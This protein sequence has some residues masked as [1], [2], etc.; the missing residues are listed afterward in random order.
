L[1]VKVLHGDT[2]SNWIH[3]G[4]TGAPNPYIWNEHAIRAAYERRRILAVLVPFWLG[5]RC[6]LAN[7][8]EVSWDEEELAWELATEYAEGSPVP[9]LH[10]LRTESD[11]F[12]RLRDEVMR[13]LVGRLRQSGFDGAVWQA[14]LGNPVAL[15]NFLLA[16]DGGGFH[17]I[18][19]ESGVPAIFPLNPL[20]LFGYYLPMCLKHRRALFDDVDVSR[21][22]RYLDEQSGV[23]AATLGS[24]TLA[25]LRERTEKLQVHQD[26]WKHQ[27][28]HERG[29]DYQLAK[30]RLSDERATYYRNRPLRWHLREIRRATRKLARWVAVE[31]PLRVGGALGKVRPAALFRRMWRFSSS[32]AYR[33]GVAR[34]YVH[35][36]LDHWE[37]RNRME[38]AHADQLREELRDASESTSYITDLGAH[39]GMKGAFITLELTVLAGL[40][41]AGVISVPFVAV[42]LALDGVISRS[43]YT[44]YRSG[45]AVARRAPL[46]WIAFLVGLAP[47]FGNSAYAV[48]MLYAANERHHHIARFILC[49]AFT[50]L[51]A[52]MPV[53]GGRDTMTEHVFN[54][55][56]NRLAKRRIA[57]P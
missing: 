53:W 44:L 10:P 54:R 35:A 25:E 30:R 36:R 1:A 34:D 20:A 43:I 56:G 11:H 5:G 32:Q 55:L 40:L 12:P 49:D 15:N 24:A 39:L 38:R 18:D 6:T 26:K 47:G 16:P 41:A 37:Q 13:P 2:L 23:L 33:T 48:Q 7:A 42:L 21:L 46:P 3:D 14:G 57:T 17:F 28:R 29:I 31:W 27:P 9:L 22:R 45:V 4:F 51:G 52:R 8:V 19:I 50:R